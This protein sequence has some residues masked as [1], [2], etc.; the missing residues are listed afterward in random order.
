MLSFPPIILGVRPTSDHAG[1]GGS[2]TTQVISACCRTLQE[3]A[4]AGC[5]LSHQYLEGEPA[6]LQGSLPSTHSPWRMDLF[7]IVASSVKVQCFAMVSPSGNPGANSLQG[8]L[9]CLNIGNFSSF[10]TSTFS[11]DSAWATHKCVANPD[12]YPLSQE[13][14]MLILTQGQRL[15]PRSELLSGPTR[16]WEAEESRVVRESN[17]GKEGGQASSMMFSEHSEIAFWLWPNPRGSICFDSKYFS[18]C[19]IVF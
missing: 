1:R 19:T 4:Q 10:L 7:W 2:K 12:S 6:E 13:E 5:V 17:H 14:C 8:Q 3:V 16:W 15:E 9:L 11:A 18:M